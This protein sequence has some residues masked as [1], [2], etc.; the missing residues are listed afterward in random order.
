[1]GL[2]SIYMFNNEENK[3][4][5]I[6]N[7]VLWFYNQARHVKDWYKILQHKENTNT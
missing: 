7:Y 1:M 6:V 5:Y 2:K 4:N 3:F